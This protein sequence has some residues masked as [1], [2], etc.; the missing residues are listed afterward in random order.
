MLSGEQAIGNN[1]TNKLPNEQADAEGKSEFVAEDESENREP[2]F[3]H[4]HTESQGKIKISKQPCKQSETEGGIKTS[5]ISHKQTAVDNE[6]TEYQHAQ[7]EIKGKIITTKPPLEQAAVTD[8]NIT[9][10]EAEN[11]VL[12]NKQAGD[13]SK[14]KLPCKLPVTEGETRATELPDEQVEPGGKTEQ[15]TVEG[16][17]T[18]SEKSEGKK[19][20]IK[21]QHTQ[22]EDQGR[23]TTTTLPSEQAEA[24]SIIKPSYDVAGK[25]KHPCKLEETESK[26]RTTELP[27]NQASTEYPHKQKATTDKTTTTTTTTELSHEQ[28]TTDDKT[29]LPHKQVGAEEKQQKEFLILQQIV[30]LLD[31][32]VCKKRKL[33]A[34]IDEKK[35]RYE[36]DFTIRETFSISKGEFESELQKD[37]VSLNQALKQKQ[38]GKDDS[39]QKCDQ[40]FAQLA[41][42]N[43]QLKESN[44]QL[45]TA[46]DLKLKLEKEVKRLSNA[47]SKLKEEINAKQTEITKTVKAIKENQK[48]IAETKAS[49]QKA[50]KRMFQLCDKKSTTESSL[51]KNN[52]SIEKLNE[53]ITKF[54][55]ELENTHTTILHVK[56]KKNERQS[57]LDE[58]EK[59]RSE[60]TK[61]QDK[62]KSDLEETTTKCDNLKIQKIQIQ[63]SLDRLDTEIE[64]IHSERRELQQSCESNNQKLILLN[65]QL[66]EHRK[67]IEKYEGD[68]LKLEKDTNEFQENH[69]IFVLSCKVCLKLKIKEMQ[70]KL[71]K[72]GI[73]C[74]KQLF[75]IWNDEIES[76]QKDLKQ[77]SKK[78]EEHEQISVTTEYSTTSL[79]LIQVL[80]DTELAYLECTT[81][82]SYVLQATIQHCL[83]QINV[84]GFVKVI[85]GNGGDEDNDTN[86]NTLGMITEGHRKKLL[87]IGNSINSNFLK[88]SSTRFC[89]EKNLL[90]CILE[91]E[92]LW[93]E[94]QQL[95][96]MFAQNVIDIETQVDSKRIS[97]LFCYNNTTSESGLI[98]ASMDG[99][100]KKAVELLNEIYC[101]QH[102]VSIVDRQ[103]AVL[104]RDNEKLR[105]SSA[106][107][108]NLKSELECKESEMYQMET[109]KQEA[110]QDLHYAQERFKEL[111]LEKCQLQKEI[112]EKELSQDKLIQTLHNMQQEL[113]KQKSEMNDITTKILQL[114]GIQEKVAKNESKLVEHYK[115]QQQLQQNL[116]EHQLPLQECG[117]D[118]STND[119]KVNIITKEM[120][121]LQE[122]IQT[123]ESNIKSNEKQMAQLDEID[124]KKSELS[125][126]IANLQKNINHTKASIGEIQSALTNNASLI[127]EC[128]A[129]EE[130]QKTKI[131]DTLNLLE[132]KNTE[133]NQIREMYIQCFVEMSI[134]KAVIGYQIEENE[135]NIKMLY[136]CKYN[137]SYEETSEIKNITDKQLKF[138][139]QLRS[140][141]LELQ[142]KNEVLKVEQDAKERT[143]RQIH[144]QEFEN[145][146]NSISDKQ[147]HADT[148]L[149]LKKKE[150]LEVQQ[151][152]ETVEMELEI[153]HQ[154]IQDMSQKLNYCENV[155]TQLNSKREEMKHEINDFLSEISTLELEV[156][157]RTVS[158]NNHK[159]KKSRMESQNKN[160][161]LELQRIKDDLV[162]V[163]KLISKESSILKDYEV[164]KEKFENAH[165]KL[166][167]EMDETR[168]TVKQSE[169][170]S[171]TAKTDSQKCIIKIKNLN[172][173]EKETKD[174]LVKTEED[175][176]R[177]LQE[178][179]NFQKECNEL[180][181]KWCDMEC[182]DKQRVE[183]YSTLEKLEKQLQS[184]DMYNSTRSILKHILHMV[185][186]ENVLEKNK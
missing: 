147:K 94:M 151:Q 78:V 34:F 113:H 155:L 54:Q 173:K 135:Q 97:M 122:I 104:E 14:D 6:A 38:K 110:Q 15:A 37:M 152:Q 139:H 2:K 90:T 176:R 29:E 85:G 148:K 118:L 185:E 36:V 32:V 117:I 67:N 163:D 167:K 168:K 107:E 126:T 68:I 123:I 23:A 150:R 125:K 106:A 3:P 181:V 96:K 162:K 114:Q 134:Q 84:D 133:Y 169:E 184:K 31:G 112:E 138:E 60:H 57:D 27:Q 98:D 30:E 99:E 50:N 47:I 93:N 64:E 88:F 81:K 183:V 73:S 24:E 119:T 53:T 7:T 115:K 61:E 159:S 160:L 79:K 165:D 146:N 105:S 86:Q 82:V 136:E 41:E 132:K 1:V 70:E 58:I 103:L 128:K 52:R 175:Y 4:N 19:T 137:L 20:E 74:L 40:L 164:R 116:K 45:A 25:T 171:E 157:E 69:N 170:E 55:K 179:E 80:Q 35:K 12:T 56:E 130:C 13:E 65:K 180:E 129:H 63:S 91:Q 83:C 26:T 39:I 131:C 87:E 10:E 28:T 121:E 156:K 154:S 95:L 178:K 62:I 71:T 75:N 101:S 18:E 111:S 143:E 17:T 33:E 92:A 5:S 161:D 59:Y 43:G 11:T 77:V 8:K 186:H 124:R 108:G 44:R 166:Q 109:Q 158:L 48:C 120:H 100:R 72:G 140:F 9:L 174:L 153:S 102:L 42:Q 49:L 16:S 46:G 149:G 76:L 142:G 127:E 141:E 89:E 145:S 182:I 144:D 177:W 66:D 172:A 51:E 22:S 21:I